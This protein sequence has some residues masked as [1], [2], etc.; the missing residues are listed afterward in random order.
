[1]P[2]DIS[3]THAPI[4]SSHSGVQDIRSYLC[5]DTARALGLSTLPWRVTDGTN[6][7]HQAF[8]CLPGNLQGAAAVVPSNKSA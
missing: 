8:H 2:A 5:K 4:L 1:M 7:M 3:S 6:S